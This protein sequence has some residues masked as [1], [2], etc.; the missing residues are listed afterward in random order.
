VLADSPLGECPHG[1]PGVANGPPPLFSM[2]P[3]FETDEIVVESVVIAAGGSYTEIAGLPARLLLVLDQSTL[4]VQSAGPPDKV[5]HAGEVIWIPAK[6]KPTFAN[7]T[8]FQSCAFVLVE[9]LDS[10]GKD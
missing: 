3:L 5:L 9:F 8:A 10:A 7:A 6:A 2:K 4:T 1:N